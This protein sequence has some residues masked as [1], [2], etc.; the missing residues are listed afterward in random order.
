MSGKTGC[1]ISKLL[2]GLA[3]YGRAALDAA[4]QA[5]DVF[6]EQVIG[7]AQ[8]LTPVKTGFLQGSGTTEPAELDGTK[9]TKRIGFNASYAAAVHEVPPDRA[10]HEVG[11]WKYLETAVRNDAPK[12]APF[13]AAQ[14]KGATGG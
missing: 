12:F 8:E 14:V 4:V 13:V 7:D 2:A 11:Q 5:T 6:G 1:D 10:H 3:G 9:V